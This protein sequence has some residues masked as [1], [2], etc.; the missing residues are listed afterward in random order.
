MIFRADSLTNAARYFY[1]I[2]H[3]GGHDVLSNYWELGLTTRQEQIFLFA[4]VLILIASDLLQ[5]FRVPVL[6]KIGAAPRPVRWAM[7][8]VAIFAFLLMGY[9]LG[10]GGFL[11]ARY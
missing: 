10:G 8:E 6:K 7:Y 11:Y 5:E 2:V 1:G 9:F 3:N 4:G